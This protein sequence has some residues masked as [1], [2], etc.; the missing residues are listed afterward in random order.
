M[1]QFGH[2][3]ENRECYPAQFK[4]SLIPEE[5]FG[6]YDMPG[7]TANGTVRSLEETSLD[8]ERDPIASSAMLFYKGWLALVLGIRERVSSSSQKCLRWNSLDIKSNRKWT[9]DTLC[10]KLAS[11]FNENNG[12]GLH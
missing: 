2:D 5:H 6:S 4:G 9:Y 3:E 11:E 1:T 8:I 10:H 7:W 12:M